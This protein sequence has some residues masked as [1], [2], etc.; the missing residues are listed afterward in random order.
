M[1]RLMEVQDITS[2]VSN[3]LDS[4]Y[5]KTSDQAGISD[6]DTK[7]NIMS[8]LD[9]ALTHNMKLVMVRP[10]QVSLARKVI[11][12]RNGNT[13]V[14]TVI[15]FPFGNGSTVDKVNEA[16]TAINMGVD[17]LDYVTD[18][19]AFKDGNID[20]FVRD[21]LS[22]TKIGL[23]NGKVVKWII[24]S[25]ALT[26][27]EIQNITKLVRD[28]VVS[29]FGE[30]SA[31]SVFIKT[32]TGFFSGDIP[33]PEK[34]KE[35]DVIMMSQNAGPLRVKASGGIYT[36]DDLNRMV[37][38]GATRIGTSTAKEILMGDKDVIKDY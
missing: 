27:E 26:L 22:G 2:D 5:L 37:K 29:E 16:K 12:Q 4:T 14:G 30:L 11:D 3:Y 21:I 24:E 19:R 20:K 6:E 33:L 15:D 9:D 17:E 25:E 13:L 8:L 28:I 10:E 34:T 7:N 31:S 23:D 38:A 35:E 32:S 1:I 36:I 18:Y